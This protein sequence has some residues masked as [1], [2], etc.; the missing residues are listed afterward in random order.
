VNSESVLS[1]YDGRK[2]LI[3]GGAGCIGSNLT[4]A[5]IKANA[6]LIVVFDDLSAA[7]E[8]N[9]PNDKRVL[10]IKGSILDEERA[11]RAFS[12]KPDYVFHLAA[13]FAN[14]NSVDHPETDLQVNGLGTLRMLE[15]SNLVSVKR[16]VFAS[17]GCSVYGSV[18]PLPLKEDF[19][20]IHLD[21]PYQIDKL[22]GELYCNYFHDYYRLP[23]AIARYFNVFGPGE[24]PGKYRNVIPKFM[25]WAMNNQPLPITG[26]GEETRDFTFVE[27]IVDGTLR[28][29]IM[30][31]ALGEA[32]N[33][34][35]ETETKVIDLA[36]WINQLT[37]NSAGIVY[38]ERRDWDKAIRR[39]A[40][41]EKARKLIG[42]AP[43]TTIKKGL[44]AVY[45]WFKDNFENIKQSAAF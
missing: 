23:V 3:T 17:S 29:G 40:S 39:R 28:M 31:G 34:A 26:T 30:D 4:K 8:W 36:N 11:K 5:L 14:Q 10:F 2:V 12:Y 7:Y 32:I 22:I 20:S 25:W 37:G 43:M 41:I 19:V 18:A 1:E 16:F 6:E 33:L 45:N 35:S 44:P 15:Y 38:S 24:V 27:D 42:Y 9:I 13:H 21:T